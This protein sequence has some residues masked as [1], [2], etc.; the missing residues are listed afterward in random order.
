MMNSKLIATIGVIFMTSMFMYHTEYGC[1]IQHHQITRKYHHMTTRTIIIT[2]TYV[3]MMMMMIHSTDP[4]QGIHC[5]G[6]GCM[7]LYNRDFHSCRLYYSN[8][9]FQLLIRFV[10]F[11]GGGGSGR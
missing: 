4:T 11:V 2:T 9:G 5:P 10:N 7:I 8:P 3:V 1:G 6:T